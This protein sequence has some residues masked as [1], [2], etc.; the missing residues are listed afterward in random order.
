MPTPPSRKPPPSG[1]T[2]LHECVHECLCTSVCTLKWLRTHSVRPGGAQNLR[3]Y[4]G[5]APATTTRP[6]LSQGGFSRED[7]CAR[8]SLPRAQR[9]PSHWQRAT[10]EVAC[11]DARPRGWAGH[12]HCD[13]PPTVDHP[14]TFFWLAAASSTRRHGHGHG[15]EREETNSRSN[16]QGWRGHNSP[17]TPCWDDDVA[18]G[19]PRVP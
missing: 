11:W 10:R 5:S 14:P 15:Y 18:G 2:R 8:G 7:G 4:D 6:P 13:I 17:N 19:A 12:Q 3:G 16:L 1:C 9:H